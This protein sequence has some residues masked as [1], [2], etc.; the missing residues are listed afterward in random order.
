MICL[1]TFFSPAYFIVAM[2]YI[3]CIY[4]AK[5]VSI[6]YVITKASGQE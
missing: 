2:Q 3:T 5:F 4:P 1:I 6:D